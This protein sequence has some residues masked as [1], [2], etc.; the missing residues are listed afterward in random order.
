VSCCAGRQEASKRVDNCGDKVF[1]ES[2]SQHS[3]SS[4]RNCEEENDVSHSWRQLRELRKLDKRK[5]SLMLINILQ[6]ARLGLESA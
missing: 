5:G 2:L 1:H 6:E 4:R 3:Q